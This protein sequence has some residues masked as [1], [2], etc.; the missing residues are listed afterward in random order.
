[1]QKI[2]D[3]ITVSSVN[4]LTKVVY[5]TF[6]STKTRWWFRGQRDFSWNLLP[7]VRRGYTRQQ[8]RYLTNLFYT[9]A[10]TRHARCP[11]DDDYGSW[12]ALMQHFGLP[13]RLLDWTNSPLIAAYFAAKYPLDMKS[14]SVTT[15]AAIWMLEPHSLNTSQGYE[16][17]F[18]PLNAGSLQK[19]LR[20]AIKGNDCSS[21]AVLA[22]SPL[23]IDMRMFVQ[24]GQFTVHVTDQE[25]NQMPGSE[26]W[27]RK[28]K[29]PAEAVSQVALELDLLGIRLADVTIHCSEVS[30]PGD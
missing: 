9:R 4:E 13:T 21:V 8:E 27:L 24:Q 26:N 7:K 6:E 10:R 14:G 25:L 15:D 2:T 11:A 30:I 19:M 28:I 12:L 17:V 16:P 5:A 1:V 20:P 23:E 3:D 22:A 18:P 29:I